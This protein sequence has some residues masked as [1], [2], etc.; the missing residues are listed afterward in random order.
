MISLL[1]NDPEFFPPV[2]CA[3]EGL[4][5]MGGDLSPRRL[6]AAYARGIFPWYSAETP[7]LWWSPDPRCALLLD[8]FHA[9]RRLLRRR[10]VQEYT[11]TFD[12]DFSSVI[13][14]CATVPR[15]G[16][17]GTW[18]VPEMAEAYNTLHRLGF[19][20]SVEAW[21]GNLLVAGMYGVGEWGKAGT[22]RLGRVFFGESMFTLVPDASKLALLELVDRLRAQGFALLD[23]QQYTPHMARF[24]AVEMKREH[25]LRMLREYGPC[26]V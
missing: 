16:H 10:R 1:T 22:G 13:H 25:F 21:Q 14:H 11:F 4:L 12:K 17:T 9:P 15:N 20:H 5:A 8:D 24:G 18:I 6:L 7:I 23:C 19:A 26:S 3:K 2:E